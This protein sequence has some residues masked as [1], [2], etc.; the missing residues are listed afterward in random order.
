MERLGRMRRGMRSWLWLSLLLMSLVL[1]GCG[2]KSGQEKGTDTTPQ[3][4]QEEKGAESKGRK[5]IGKVEGFTEKELE[6]LCGEWFSVYGSFR[7]YEEDGTI[8]E[9]FRMAADDVGDEKD[10]ILYVEDGALY[11][12]YR[13]SFMSYYRIPIERVK[14]KLYE[15]YEG[16]DWCLAG[17]KGRWEDA[18][19]RFG[20]N[21]KQELMRYIA[22]EEEE[23]RWEYQNLFLKKG[24]ENSKQ[25]EDYRYKKVVTVS[26]AEE[27]AAA[28]E[29]RTKIILK[30]GAYDLTELRAAGHTGK[31]METYD[32]EITVSGFYFDNM[33]NICIEAESKELTELYI[34]DAYRP[35]LPLYS[36]NHIKFRGITLGHRINPGYCSGSVLYLNRSGG[37]DLE[38][39]KLYGC[40]SYGLEADYGNEIH[41][42]NS[43]IYSC[44]YGIMDLRNIYSLTAENCEFHDNSGYSML[45]AVESSDIE[46]RNC[47][48]RNNNSNTDAF[49][50]LANSW[51]VNLKKCD[52][53]DNIYSNFALNDPEEDEYAGKALNVE[54]CT[55]RDKR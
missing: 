29:S 28:I 50:S 48:F 27:L 40:G 41:L 31:V 10:L 54:K 22:G 45:S 2:A 12:D 24:S 11:A 9:S 35:V 18:Q 30:P 51:G 14:E 6:L 25:I 39:C 52:F 44:T 20:L 13:D 42:K 15:G 23:D 26:T 46:I 37:I 8:N 5:E 17:K 21:E 33:Q 32:S 49:V 1:I 4:K 3:G 19:L 38:D 16:N 55:F 47:R 53:E 43:E 7:Y 34:T 36:S